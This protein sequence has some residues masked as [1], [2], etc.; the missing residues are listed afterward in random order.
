M[1]CVRLRLRPSLITV[2]DWCCCG[3]TAR[4]M[5]D[6]V[7][8]IAAASLALATV[9]GMCS[10]VLLFSPHAALGDTGQ[11]WGDSAVDVCTAAG[12]RR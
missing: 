2:M 6:E 3:Q 9:I 11:W 7:C 5:I 10:S 12:R 1:N 8:G 4:L